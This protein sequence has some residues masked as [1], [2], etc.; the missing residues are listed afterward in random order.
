M[1]AIAEGCAQLQ[2]LFLSGCRQVNDASLRH[3]GKHCHK[4]RSVARAAMLSCYE[5]LN[6]PSLI[7]PQWFLEVAR[8]ISRQSRSPFDWWSQRHA[9]RKISSLRSWWGLVSWMFARNENGMRRRQEDCK[10][11]LIL[12]LLGSLVSKGSKSLKVFDY[13][14]AISVHLSISA[15]LFNSS[16]PRLLQQTAEVDEKKTNWESHSAANTFVLCSVC[17]E[18]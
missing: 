4:L 9:W 18:R 16:L 8:W 2:H 17:S 11:D 1:C 14:M 3:L 12:C 7:L 6:H 15:M 5:I 13:M 10:V